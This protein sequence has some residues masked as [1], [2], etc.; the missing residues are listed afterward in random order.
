VNTELE[1][2]EKL[3][4]AT[5]VQLQLRNFIPSLPQENVILTVGK[6]IDED[7]KCESV[8]VSKQD[9]EKIA[10]TLNIKINDLYE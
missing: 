4:R 1:Q 9:A 3:T 5:E 2:P 10:R 8:T 6:W 7:Y